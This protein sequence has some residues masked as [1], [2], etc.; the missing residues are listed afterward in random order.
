MANS[1]LSQ[2]DVDKIVKAYENGSS[3]T[4]LAD[5]YGVSTNTILNRLRAEGV[6]IRPRGRAAVNA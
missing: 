1:K 6:E 3:S 2:K 4:A 5:I